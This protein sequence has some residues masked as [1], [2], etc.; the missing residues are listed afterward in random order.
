ME[1]FSSHVGVF[2]SCGGVLIV[3]GC[4]HRVGV[5]S[6]HGGVLV[7]RGGVLVARGGVL[8]AGCVLVTLMCCGLWSSSMAMSR[9]V[10]WHLV[11]Q[12]GQDKSGT[13]VLTSQY[14]QQQRTM[15]D[16]YLPLFDVQLSCHCWQHGTCIPH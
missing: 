10:M 13:G 6:L 3:Q 2:S 9:G 15:T 1:V 4:A 12:G 8:V 14:K 5:S 11:R 7:A 16:V